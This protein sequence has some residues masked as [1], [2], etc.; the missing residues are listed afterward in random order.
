MLSPYQQLAY[1]LLP[2]RQL[3]YDN[4][5]AALEKCRA[6][7]DA[8]LCFGAQQAVGFALRALNTTREAAGLAPVASPPMRG[9]DELLAAAIE[10]QR[11]SLSRLVA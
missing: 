11:H 5:L 3:H 8:K 7:G 9:L 2:E 10:A 4:T 1:T 6:N